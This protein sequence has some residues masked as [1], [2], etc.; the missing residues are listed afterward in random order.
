MGIDNLPK[1]KK[2]NNRTKGVAKA[3]KLQRRKEAEERQASYD[4]LSIDQK[5][6]QPHLGAKERKK[7]LARKQATK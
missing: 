3:A 7:L 4:K 5:L 1:T 6:A 2:Q